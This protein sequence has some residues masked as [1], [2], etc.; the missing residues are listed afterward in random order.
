MLLG[1]YV[2]KLF[3]CLNPDGVVVGNARTGVEG[4]DLN[5]VWA[6]PDD[7]LHPTV[8]GVWRVLAAEQRSRGVEAF[9]DL[10]T[11]SSRK[12]SFMYGCPLPTLYSFAGWSRAHLL[13]KMFGRLTPLFS[14]KDS[15]FVIHHSKVSTIPSPIED[16]GPCGRLGA[17]ACRQ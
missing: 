6:S 7:S 13:P 15:L 16:H 1:L 17:S 9:C 12:Q 4:A 5:R 8:A 11:H 10:H 2:F 3:V 14:Y